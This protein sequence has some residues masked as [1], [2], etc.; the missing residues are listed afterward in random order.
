MV[1]FEFYCS[2]AKTMTCAA[3]FLLKGRCKV[4]NEK[5]TGCKA[6]N[7]Q[8]VRFSVPMNEYE[9]EMFL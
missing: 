1:N 6:I 7:A 9:K 2:T 8:L 4:S 3:C 5:R